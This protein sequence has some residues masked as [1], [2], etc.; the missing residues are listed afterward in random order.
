MK[1]GGQVAEAWSAVLVELRQLVG[2][3]SLQ[4]IATHSRQGQTALS[5]SSVA[6]LLNG[7]TTPRLS[8]VEAFVRACLSIAR[9]RTLTAEQR[10]PKHWMAR[11]GEAIGDVPPVKAVSGR[12]WNI[13]ARLARFAGREELLSGLRPEPDLPRVVHGMAGVGKTSA[14]LEYVHRHADDY[15]VAWWVPSENADLIPD[16]LAALARALRLAGETDDSAVAVARLIGELRTRDRW[17]LVFDNAE[18][19]TALTPYLPGGPGHVLITSRRTDWS[20]IAAGAPVEEF[21]RAESV[22]LL[23]SRTT[24]LSA[25]EAEQVAEAVGD[26]PLAID[27]AGALLAD[28]TLS[29]ADYLELLSARADEL[30]AMENGSATYPVS[31]AAAWMVAFDKLAEDSPATLYFLMLMAWLAPEPI[32]VSLFTQ[33]GGLPKELAMWAEDPL[34]FT[35]VLTQIRKRGLARVETDAV[36][37]HRIPAALLRSRTDGAKK[38]RGWG[39]VVLILLRR[40]V[41]SNVWDNP[42]VWPTWDRLLPHVLAAV[43]HDHDVDDDIFGSVAW[44]LDRAGSYLHTR[45]EVA[46]AVLLFERAH[47]LDLDQFGPGHH[48]TLA[49]A[50]NLATALDDLRQ[51]KRARALKEDILRRRRDELGPDHEKTLQAAHAFASVLADLDDNEQAYALNVDTWERRKRLFGEDD[52]RTL[53]TAGNLATNLHALGDRQGARA[54]FEDTLAR[55]RRV[56]GDDHPSTL[57][58]A[59]NLAAFL[60]LLGESGRAVALAEGTLERSR[61]VLGEDHPT[62]RRMTKILDLVSIDDQR[63]PRMSVRRPG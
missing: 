60:S 9:R 4:T 3:P 35:E 37:L 38:P 24:K 2:N 1:E 13:P 22:R 18:D 51:Y 33:G 50:G 5:K 10:D 15:D 56:Q 8:S 61:R 29:V 44:L 30:L 54:L 45:G 59:G 26:L 39:I 23:R 62:T 17:L 6:N 42:D 40:T 57:L 63:A 7:V 43:A 12:A 53:S 16:R 14:I 21:S 34:R 52:P 20:D 31:V 55:S 36:Q 28:T 47:Q 46:S 19:P 27:Q 58:M 11:Y 48:N 41:P 25:F 32:P 49:T